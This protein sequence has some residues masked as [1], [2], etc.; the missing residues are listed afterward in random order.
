MKQNGVTDD[1]LRLYLFPYSLT[2]HATT[3]FDRL[4]KNSIH[5]FQEMASKFL[6]KYIPPS[7]MTKV[8]NDISNFRQ[9][10]DES[11]FEAWERYKISIDR[12]PNHN[13]LP[14]T[15]T[16][17][18]YTEN[19][20]R[21]RD[22]DQRCSRDIS[23]KRGDSS[24]SITSS[25]LEIA[26]L[27]QQMV[28][29]RKDMLQMYRINQQVNSVSLSCKTCGGPH[30]YYE[31]QAVGGCTQD[32]LTESTI[33]VPPPVVQPSPASTSSEPPPAPISSP[34][35]PEPNPHQPL[36]PYP[37][38]LNK[39]KLHDK[40]D[41]Q[42]IFAKMVKD[43][44]TNKEKLLEMANTTLNENCSVVL[45]KMLPEKLGD[46][47]RFLIPCDFYG[48]ES[49]MALADLGASINL[50]PLS[51]WKTLSLP[52]LSPTRMTLELATRTVAYPA[53]IAEDV[54]V[55]VGKF[56]FPADFFVVDYDVDPRVPLILGRPFLRTGHALADVHGEELNLRVG[57]EKLVFNVESTSK[58]PRKH[59][60]ESIHKIDILDITCEDHFHEVLNVQKL[61]NPMSGNP[62]PS[63]DPV[64]ASLSLSLTPFGNSDFILK[65]IDTFLASDDSTS[66]DVDDRTFNMEGD[67]R[68]IETL[69]NND[70]SN[71][72]PPPFPVF[73]I[74][75][76]EKNKSS[77]DDPPD[78]ELK[79]LPPHPIRVYKELPSYHLTKSAHF[80]PMREDDTLEKLTRQ[81]LKEVVSKHGVPVSI[82]SDRDGKFTSHFW[83]S[84]NKALGT[85][86][87]MSTAYHPDTDGQS[88]RTIQTLE[89]M[90]RACVLD[91]GK[92]W[93]QGCKKR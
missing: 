30:A 9:L 5:T 21:S 66:P 36:I 20:V 46:T 79:D 13:L 81:Y 62:T 52:E 43:L 41:I 16:Y 69:L 71:D 8:R 12:C 40:A 73:E 38:R 19:L 70:I 1:A 11:L 74:N 91:F 44:L 51:V 35:I 82:I 10:P 63:S 48:L 3:W 88:E 72:L 15:Q 50:M 65:E 32:V 37:S 27:T 80:L 47:G 31:C 61:I 92:G 17:T 25:S 54:F 68:L 2:H 89:D 18:F 93:D 42:F 23:E 45:L 83:K 67:I 22:T 7:M 29:M 87:D 59:G 86:L 39:E 24:S 60:D 78:L 55:Q 64:V 85:R 75:E 26:A 56:T 4:P 49:C 33:R 90:L 34:M 53:G 84:L 76:T 57:D 14:V 6:S 58:Y 77:I 28:E